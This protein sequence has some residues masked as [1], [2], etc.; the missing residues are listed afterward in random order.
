VDSSSFQTTFLNGF[1]TISPGL[2]K[3]S[4]SHCLHTSDD[5][6]LQRC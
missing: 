2:K 4:T 3:Y 5:T 1:K 6:T